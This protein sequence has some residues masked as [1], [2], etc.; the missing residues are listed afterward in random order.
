MK[1]R[2]IRC[3][4]WLQKQNIDTG[5]IILLSANNRLDNYVVPLATFFVGAVYHPFNSE[6]VLG[7]KLEN[8][9]KIIFKNLIYSIL[10]I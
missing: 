3:A 8:T 4:L 5:D 1:D 7:N 6:E 2:S 10:F 9:R